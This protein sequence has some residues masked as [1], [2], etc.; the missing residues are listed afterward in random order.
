MVVKIENDILQGQDEIMDFFRQSQPEIITRSGHLRAD[1]T[2]AILQK[3][4]PKT[5]SADFVIVTRS[6]IANLHNNKVQITPSKSGQGLQTDLH[7]KAPI[8]LFEHGE[9]PFPIGLSEQNGAYTVKKQDDKATARIVFSQRNPEAAVIF[10]LVDENI[11]RMASIGFLPDKVRRLSENEMRVQQSQGGESDVRI[12]NENGGIDI[13]QSL[14]L[15][16]SITATGADTGAFK[17]ALSRGDV[18]GEKLS[19]SLKTIFQKLAGPKTTWSPGW[20]SEPEPTEQ[21]ILAAVEV[22]P[23]RVFQ[24]IENRS[25]GFVDSLNQKMNATIR[26]ASGKVN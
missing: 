6:E 8:V 26:K 15:E 17:Q 20:S 21:D 23:D 16:W 9:L 11:L 13:V 7:E 10:G 22:L 19:E 24:V 4:D 14:L 2:Q 25:A 12:V 18:G 1:S 5:M 3:S